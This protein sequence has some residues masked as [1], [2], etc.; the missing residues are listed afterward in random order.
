[1]TIKPGDSWGRE[2]PRP[3]GAVTIEGDHDV[4][5][6]LQR[7]SPAAVVVAA[8]DLARTLGVVSSGGA[9]AER[10]TVNE[11]P[12][13]L[14]QVSL[15]GADP[16]LACAH[17]VA[18]SPWYRGHWLRG[19]IL[20]VMNAEFIGDWDIAPRGHPNDGRVEVV[21]VA[22]TM[23]WR[24]RIGARRRLPSATHLPH[25]GIATRSVR[26][27]SWSFARPLEVVVDGQRVGRAST[28]AVV[29]VADAAIVYA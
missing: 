4:V 1:M 28:I 20:A 18:R 14:V 17:V 5:P 15:D 22:S 27:H 21:E 16:V 10:S 12:I 26:R 8:G 11:L 7:G 6:A 19:P 24:D 2:V 13:D 23:S 25:P 3:D 9:P 29:V